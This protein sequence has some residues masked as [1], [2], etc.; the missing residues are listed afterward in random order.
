ML[1]LAI[2]ASVGRIGTVIN[3]DCGRRKMSVCNVALAPR[4]VSGR[5]FRAIVRFVLSFRTVEPSANPVFERPPIGELAIGVQ[6]GADPTLGTAHLGRFWERVRTEFSATEDHAPIGL[7][8]EWRQSKEG[9]PLP[10]LWLV[11]PNGT[12]VLQLQT[13]RFQLNWRRVA[14][15]AAYPSFAEHLELFTKYWQL[16]A[17]FLKDLGMESPAIRAAEVLKISHIREIGDRYGSVEQ[18]IPSAALMALGRLWNISNTA[19]LLDLVR[20]DAKVHA[21]LKTGMLAD[22]S[23]RSVLILE[24]RADATNIDPTGADLPA[25]LAEANAAANLAF[26]SLTS[27]EVQRDIWKRIR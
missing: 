13:G 27:P 1:A 15:N 19:M 2:E 3:R 10:R 12:H 24:L 4:S 25:R 17:A 5:T 16:F 14:D 26:T 9:L 7:P 20:G 21:E 22:A 6:F 23:R 11:S 18:I 8:L